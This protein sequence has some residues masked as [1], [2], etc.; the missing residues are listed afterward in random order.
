MMKMNHVSFEY[1][2]VLKRYFNFSAF[3][4][5]HSRK[6]IRGRPGIHGQNV[7][8]KNKNKKTDRYRIFKSMSLLMILR[9][10]W[11]NEGKRLFVVI[12]F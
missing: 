12:M 1:S 5:C 4:Q 11:T 3:L 9:V 7:E 10:V 8:E 2:L 6:G